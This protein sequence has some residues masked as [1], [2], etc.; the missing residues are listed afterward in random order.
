MMAAWVANEV[1]KEDGK[2][3]ILLHIAYNN[4]ECCPDECNLLRCFSQTLGVPLY[5]RQITEMQRVRVSSLRTV[6]EEVTRRIRFAFYRHFACPVILGHN[7]DD[8]FENVFQN[9]SK[10]IHFGNLFG[11]QEVGEEQGVPILRPF[12]DVPKQLLVAFA[13]RNRI[14]HLYDSTPAWSR[15]GQ[16]RDRLIPGIQQFDPQILAGL[17]AFVERTRFLE[18][19]WS[20]SMDRWCSQ[21]CKAAEGMI[22]IPKDSFWESNYKESQFWVRLFQTVG[23]SR[24]SNK[25]F[26]NFMDMLERRSEGRCNLSGS[27][28]ATWTPYDLYL[29]KN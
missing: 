10:Q 20:K 13:D 28:I 18:D 4:R 5:I 14:P 29:K 11:M 23:W 17:Q 8:C 24:P 3:L 9:L 27:M 12:L 25:S 26:A 16:M 1:C 22:R 19:Q 15:R 2:E 7:L 6:Y 21:N